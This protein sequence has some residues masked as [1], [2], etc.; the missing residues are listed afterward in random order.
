MNDRVPASQGRG[1]GEVIGTANT[2]AARGG[3]RVTWM[4]A[5]DPLP[6]PGDDPCQVQLCL[7]RGHDAEPLLYL[8]GLHGDWTL[9]GGFHRAVR[10]RCRFGGFTYPR[11]EDWT[12]D[13]YARDLGAAL[14]EA[15][16]RSG[17]LLAESFGSQV[18]WAMV[19][20]GESRFR[21]RGIILAGG[22]VRH[23]WIGGVHLVR[24]I[25]D[26]MPAWMLRGFLRAWRAYTLLRSRGNPGLQAA[27]ESFV[28]RRNH[29][30]RRAVIRR[31]DLIAGTD[32]RG[33]AAV[34]EV[35]VWHL[36][37]FWD[38]IV[39]WPLVA[40]WLRR[41]CVG[42]RGERVILRADHTVLVV[43]PETS[44]ETALGWLHEGR[45]SAADRT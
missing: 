9:V 3:S 31:L 42:W 20:M 19:R 27:V 32:F 33:V 23:P 18:A 1:S 10:G 16:V 21:V 12:L 22:F 15:G 39:P 25:L 24:W 11:R 43:A 5:G 41:W 34:A 29:A 45:T 17:W 4:D 36:T 8:P 38:P 28:A 40:P 14:E 44:A 6:V 2:H 13:D 37:G 35:P 30:D 7:E 26:R